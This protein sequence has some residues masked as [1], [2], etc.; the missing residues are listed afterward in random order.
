MQLY[1]LGIELGHLR[2]FAHQPVQ[3]VGLFVDH[4]QQIAVRPASSAGQTESSVDT[5]A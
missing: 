3:A 2:R 1:M 5:D 4:S